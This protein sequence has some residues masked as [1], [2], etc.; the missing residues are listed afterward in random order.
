ML[1]K[2]KKFAKSRVAIAILVGAV[3]GGSWYAGCFDEGVEFIED[4]APV[5]AEE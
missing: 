4:N 1:D 2:L 5:E 3:A